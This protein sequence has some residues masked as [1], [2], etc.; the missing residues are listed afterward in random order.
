MPQGKVQNSVLLFRQR[1]QRG[2]G[3]V[4]IKTTETPPLPTFLA[5]ISEDTSSS[6]S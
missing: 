1:Q 5:A 4:R 6:P 2:I 3:R